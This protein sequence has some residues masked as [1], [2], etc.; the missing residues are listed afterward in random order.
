M[1][2]EDEKQAVSTKRFLSLEDVTI[3]VEYFL[4]GEPTEKNNFNNFEN[5]ITDQFT[6]LGLWDR[7]KNCP[8]ETVS[9][10]MVLRNVKM[11]LHQTYMSLA[12]GTDVWIALKNAY[13]GDKPGAQARLLFQIVQEIPDRDM[14]KAVIQHN[15]NVKDIINSFGKTMDTEKIVQL[16]FTK[17]LPE[18]YHQARSNAITAQTFD[19]GNLTAVLKLLSDDIKVSGNKNK[20]LKGKEESEGE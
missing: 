4:C 2:E 16:F 13:K 20:L 5:W 7:G 15:E 10:G 3:P 9:R 12:N 19:F 1:G 11:A 17:N 8:N 14:D 18:I 6:M